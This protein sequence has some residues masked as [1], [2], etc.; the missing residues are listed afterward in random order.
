MSGQSKKQLKEHNIK[1]QKQMIKI[2][3]RGSP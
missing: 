3:K 1:T 2:E